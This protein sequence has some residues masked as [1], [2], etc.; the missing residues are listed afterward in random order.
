MVVD[1]SMDLF[2]YYYYSI[3]RLF[4]NSFIHWIIDQHLDG[5]QFC[6]TDK[7]KLEML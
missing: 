7:R 4:H 5:F 6:A 1:A 2:Y 3:L